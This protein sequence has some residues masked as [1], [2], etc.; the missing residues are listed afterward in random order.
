MAI[1]DRLLGRDMPEIAQP[2]MPVNERAAH[3]EAGQAR[4]PVFDGYRPSL[5]DND[6]VAQAD[7]DYVSA[8][9][10]N[11]SRNSGFLSGA[12]DTIT[13]FVVGEGLRLNLRPD[14]EALGWTQEEA[15][16]FATKVEN[17][18]NAYADDAE[19]CDHAGTATMADMQATMVREYLMT[20]EVLGS[21]RMNVRT[22]TPFMTRLQLLEPNRLAWGASSEKLFGNQHGIV[23]DKGGKPKSYFVR[24]RWNNEAVLDDYVEL[25]ATVARNHPSGG[26]AQTVHVFNKIGAGTR[27]GVSPF[28]TALETAIRMKDLNTTQMQAASMAAQIVATIYTSREWKEIADSLGDE[29]APGFDAYTSYLTARS[30]YYQ[31]API[32]I[33]SEARFNMLMPGENMDFHNTSGAFRDYAVLAKLQLQEFAAAIGLSYEFV[34]M[35]WSSASYSSARLATAKDWLHITKLRKNIPAAF[36]QQFFQRWLADC[37]NTGLVDYPGG[38]A[39]FLSERVF[40]CRS[41]WAGPKAPSADPLKE[42]RAQKIALDSGFTNLDEQASAGG[43]DWQQQADQ[44][45]REDRYY[46]KKG[47]KSPYEAA[48]DPEGEAIDAELD[49]EDANERPPAQQP[50]P[51][52]DIPDEPQPGPIKKTEDE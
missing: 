30:S 10:I 45:A 15:S 7:R 42:V 44:R 2:T 50:S 19:S 34:S 38:I 51:T 16:D 37:I 49:A 35:D 46:R 24:T 43:R 26:F 25:P 12:A 13:N 52:T 1:W 3:H 39:A 9:A 29:E 4:I 27:R 20:G 31:N 23:T 11:L 22:H 21:V 14:A 47:L 18:W 40:A 32:N 33:A 28:V 17:L 41:N 5:V 6:D 48:D 8:R 36:M